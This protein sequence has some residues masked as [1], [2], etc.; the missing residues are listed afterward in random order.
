MAKSDCKRVSKQET[1]LHQNALYCPKITF[2]WK[3]SAESKCSFTN[4]AKIDCKQVSKQETYLHQN[5][6]YCPKIIRKS[7]F[8]THLANDY[9][10]CV[11]E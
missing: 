3:T 10:K 9:T 4:L 7:I 11:A 1:Y 6:L 5:A 8:S 2:T